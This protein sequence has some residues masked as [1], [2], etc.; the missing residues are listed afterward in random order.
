MAADRINIHQLVSRVEDNA[1]V[2]R[3]DQGVRCLGARP[4][5][6]MAVQRRG[7]LASRRL[8]PGHIDALDFWFVYIGLKLVLGSNVGSV[9]DLE[10]PYNDLSIA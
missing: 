2:L 5:C 3:K 9:A 10:L 4:L 8:Y 1:A 7:I 6:I